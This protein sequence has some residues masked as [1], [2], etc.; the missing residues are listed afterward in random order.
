[1]P[2]SSPGTGR[3]S[4]QQEKELGISHSPA[5]GTHLPPLVRAAAAAWARSLPGGI[6]SNKELLSPF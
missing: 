6:W 4:K 5:Q 1:M 2:G 3:R